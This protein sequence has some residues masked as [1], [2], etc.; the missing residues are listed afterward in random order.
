M[1]HLKPRS[2]TIV[3]YQGDDLDRLGDL[4]READVAGRLSAAGG[5]RLGDVPA[6]RE[7][8]EAFVDDAADRA[9]EVEIHALGRLR[10]TELMR[11]HP[12]R[13]VDVDGQDGKQPHP[14]DT[15]WDVNVETFPD[16]L[17]TYRDGDKRTIAR[18]DFGSV[19]EARTFVDEELAE[20]DYARMWQA[21]YLLNR[22]PSGDPKAVTFFDA[23]PRSDET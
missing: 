20:G 13:D 21:A 4:K 1:T 3:I 22:S 10:F 5:A 7:A 8:Y 6:A 17:L 18:P 2:A 23:S 9:V 15:D 19:E 14:D 16:A 11:T 12:P